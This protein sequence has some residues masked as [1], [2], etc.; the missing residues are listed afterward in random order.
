VA[1]A[2]A[3]LRVPGV[4]EGV[5]RLGSRVYRLDLRPEA[6]FDYRPG[7]FVNLLLPDGT[8]RSYSLASVLDNGGALSFHIAHIPGGAFSGWVKDGAVPGDTVEI[9]GPMGACFYTDE[10]PGQPLLLAAT[11]TGLAPLYGIARDALRQ[12][13]RG[14]IHLFHGSLD[15]EGLYLVD[16]LRELAVANP[17]LSY[18]PCVLN[19]PAPA[20]VIEGNLETLV[21]DRHADLAGFRVFLCGHPD[22]VKAMQRRVFLAGASLNAIFADAFL[23][24]QAPANGT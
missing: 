15:A 3:A 23:P 1:G 4:V 5:E 11:G 2:A 14:P 8:L 21:L 7:Q 17:S 13:H 10:D 16:E 6:P 12:G 24:S 9:Q 19:G 18:T 22:F 20:G